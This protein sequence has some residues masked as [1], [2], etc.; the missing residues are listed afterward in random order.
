[1][2]SSCFDASERTVVTSRVKIYTHETD[3][4]FESM[5]S[6]FLSLTQHNVLWRLQYTLR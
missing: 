3:W 6:S 4:L 1:M 2:A 5:M